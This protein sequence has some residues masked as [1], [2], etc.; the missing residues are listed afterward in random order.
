MKPPSLLHCDALVFRGLVGNEEVGGG[1]WEFHLGQYAKEYAEC[2]A[3]TL[4]YVDN[5]L[6]KDVECS[7]ISQLSSWLEIRENVDLPELNIIPNSETWA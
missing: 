7:A 2:W 1:N 6:L 4:I 5:E 3:L